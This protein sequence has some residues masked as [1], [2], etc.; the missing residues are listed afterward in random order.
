MKKNPVLKLIKL[1]GT[2]AELAR[3]LEKTPQAIGLWKKKRRVPGNAIRKVLLL[4]K[5]NGFELTV[6]DLL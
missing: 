1:W 4:A 2:Q 6:E 3:A 5:E